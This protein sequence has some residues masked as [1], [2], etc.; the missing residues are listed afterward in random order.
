M[1]GIP[2]LMNNGSVHARGSD[3]PGEAEW[4]KLAAERAGAQASTPDT[5]AGRSG[6]DETPKSPG[7]ARQTLDLRAINSRLEELTDRSVWE[8]QQSLQDWLKKKEAGQNPGEFRLTEFGATIYRTPGGNLQAPAEQKGTASAVKMDLTAGMP[9]GGRADAYFHTHPITALD[10]RSG[11]SF[12]LKDIAEFTS[13]PGI[14]A[15]VVQSKNKDGTINQQFALLRTAQTQDFFN[16]PSDQQRRILEAYNLRKGH[17]M[18][19]L[20]KTEGEATRI[21]D[22]ELAK[23]SGLNLVYYEGKGGILERVEPEDPLAPAFWSE[24]LSPRSK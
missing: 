7:T 19:K 16:L 14:N 4:R 23:Y 5:E 24:H 15:F 6:I 12:S 18:Y 8:T 21:A 13:A 20:G 3:E 1:G 11:H 9:T 17:L 10:E 22:S 2:S